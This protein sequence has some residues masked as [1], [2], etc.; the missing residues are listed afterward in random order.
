MRARPLGNYCAVQPDDH[1]TETSSGI[2]LTKSHSVTPEVVFG[3]VLMCG[4]DVIAVSPGDRVVY[5]SQ[6][7]HPEQWEPFAADI[8]GGDEGKFAY[9]I[10]CY[11]RTFGSSSEAMQELKDRKERLEKLKAR[12]DK[13]ETDS[14][15]KREMVL[16]RRRMNQIM[17]EQ[18]R[19]G[20]NMKAFDIRL[21][22][23]GKGRGILGVVSE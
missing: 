17:D 5:E 19:S 1:T 14:E 21:H 3:T 4:R 13:G 23:P 15:L 10:P 18:S 20:R 7:G 9:L 6:S 16:H 22:D 2:I 11:K 8:F 12:Y